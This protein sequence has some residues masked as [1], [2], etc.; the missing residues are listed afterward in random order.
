LGAGGGW[1]IAQEN[2]NGGTE[3]HA[4]SPEPAGDD[5]AA[6]VENQGTAVENQGTA[7]EN[8]GAAAENEGTAAE[9]AGDDGTV[10]EAAPATATEA[11]AHFTG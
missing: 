7:T 4:T 1:A 5:T 2:E 8:E 6:P 10:P 11:P 9:P 3:T